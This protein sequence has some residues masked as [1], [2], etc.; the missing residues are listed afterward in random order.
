MKRYVLAGSSSYVA[1]C[2]GASPP[3][4]AAAAGTSCANLAALT[5]P[6]VTVNAATLVAAGTFTPP[7][8]ADRA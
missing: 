7:G 8:S 2:V 5:I 3:G 1:A 4:L 6:N